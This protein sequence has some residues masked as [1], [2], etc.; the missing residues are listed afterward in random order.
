[1]AT[2]SIRI[3][4]GAT[5]DRS[6]GN[7]FRPIVDAARVARQA[8]EDEM[9][10][11]W[12]A[13]NGKGAVKGGAQGP[14]RSVVRAA[15]KA[16]DEVVAAE[17]RKQTKIASEEAKATRRREAAERHVARIRDRHFLEQQRQGERAERTAARAATRDAAATR[18]E[19]VG[20][21]RAVGGGS[22]ETLGKIGRGA[23]GVAGSVARG[24][25]VQT[26][27]A[28][29]VG[30][31]V[32]L[33]TRAGEL[34]AAAYDEKRDKG[35]RIDPRT[36]VR[37]GR[38]V[39]Q[40]AAF[41]P[42]KVLEGLQAFVGKTGDL[43]TGQAALPGLAKLARATGTSLEA[44]VGSAGEAAKALGDV[45]PGKE[46]ETAEEKG[47]AL[48]NVLRLIAGQ[49]KVGA[50]EMKDLAQY[51][52]RLAAASQAFGGDAA[53]N[54]GDMGALA[55]LSVA[56]GGAASAAEAAVA[57]A[58]FA[59]TLKTPARAKEFAAH[60]VEIQNQKEG[61]F[62]SVRDILKDASA[63]AIGRG[64]LDQGSLEFKKMFAN[65]KGAQAADPAFQAYSKAFR[66]NLEVTK[67]KTKADEAGKK[68]IDELFDNFGK[69]I[70]A[71]EEKDSFDRSMKTSAAQVQLFN[72]KLGEIGGKIA[73]RVL[74]ELSK[75]QPTIIALA[76]GFA[77]MV[78]F[79]AENP[80]KAGAIALGASIAKAAV[81]N[82]ITSG[83]EKLIAGAASKGGGLALGVAAITIATATLIAQSL[84]DEREKGAAG[85]LEQRETAKAE[86][87]KV[88]AALKAG[89]PAAKENLDVLKAQRA[90]VQAQ[91]K[92]GQ[93]Y[94][95][96]GKTERYGGEGVFDRIAGGARQLYDVATTPTTMEDIGRGRS[97]MQAQPELYDTRAKLD[98][99]IA[100]IEAQGKKTQK[101]EITN[102]PAAAGPVAN[103][104]NTTK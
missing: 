47:R 21:I 84:I 15:E 51:G 43:A 14:Y 19:N 6:I 102:L 32:E 42:A 55:Q 89:D 61:G 44:M 92:E 73:E 71:T 4:V 70:S 59:N 97:A 7:A 29:F 85:A 78:S 12:A 41:D 40:E 30:Q 2:E 34:S 79:A 103:A 87:A 52:G 80:I 37:L 9:E 69:A 65:V 48:V 1:M 90:A 24:A 38:D 22:I 11:A 63:G 94:F 58:G 76:Q 60:G 93:A 56:R 82:V 31:A 10:R 25:G 49:G 72:N 50:V 18:K 99:L 74:P 23:L 100:A 96:S 5:V 104:S 81:G 86:A 57:V 3:R 54:L 20:R 67:D 62:R 101:V 66:Q 17:R 68:A 95:E 13:V 53:K 16:A 77:T 91:I 28:S 39:G 45:G 26:D 33:E 8:V 75:L 36:L 83:V 46:F 27:L 64:G 88:D 35:K 98:A